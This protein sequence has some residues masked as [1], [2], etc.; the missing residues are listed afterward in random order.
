MKKTDN[1]NS[2]FSNDSSIKRQ[3]FN[4]LKM[5]DNK[6][7][8][9]IKKLNKLISLNKDF[10]SMSL[11]KDSFINSSNYFIQTPNVI[12]GKALKGPVEDK[13]MR[14]VKG[15]SIV[16]GNRIYNEVYSHIFGGKDINNI[17]KYK[18]K[19]NFI[20]SLIYISKKNNNI[21]QEKKQ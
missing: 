18:S 10:V 14:N 6:K 9:F 21:K 20:I 8:F 5:E 11:I 15:Y 16:G 4:N 7:I 12:I 2:S 17:T 19:N 13:N 3:S 1:Y